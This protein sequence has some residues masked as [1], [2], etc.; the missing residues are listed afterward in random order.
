[1]LSICFEGLIEMTQVTTFGTSA[2]T[3]ISQVTVF[4]FRN[5]FFGCATVPYILVEKRFALDKNIVLKLNKEIK[6]E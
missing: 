5:K 2:F 1:M 3:P 4:S 6:P